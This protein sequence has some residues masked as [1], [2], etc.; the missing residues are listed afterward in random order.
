MIYICTMLILMTQSPQP[1]TRASSRRPRSRSVVSEEDRDH[2]GSVQRRP[3][4]RSR[5]RSQTPSVLAMSKRSETSNDNKGVGRGKKKKALEIPSPVPSRGESV[6][7]EGSP[8]DVFQVCVFIFP[9][10]TC[11]C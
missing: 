4:T 10:F 6:E 8:V 11:V 3:M 1:G 2:Q 7:L 5:S 9:N